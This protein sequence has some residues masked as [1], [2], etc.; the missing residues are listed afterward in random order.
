MPNGKPGDHPLTD[1]LVHNNEVFGTPVDGL[2]RELDGLGLWAS[3][4][5]S[6]WLY[7]R[8]WDYRETRQR[9]GESEVRRVLERLESSLA[10]EVQR[11]KGS[12]PPSS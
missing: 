8:Y 4:I 6:E 12:Q 10:G 11:L 2:V 1:I 3:A 7:E 9:G 5:A